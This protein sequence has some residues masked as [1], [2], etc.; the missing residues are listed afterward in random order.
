MDQ[1]Q[2]NMVKSLFV[3]GISLVLVS[4]FFLNVVNPILEADR[5][6]FLEKCADDE[7]T[8]SVPHYPIFYIALGVIPFFVF[9]AMFEYLEKKRIHNWKSWK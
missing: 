3:S 6:E 2:T 4:L 8:C 5:K 9:T 1:R 7:N